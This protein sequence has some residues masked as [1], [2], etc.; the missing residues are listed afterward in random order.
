MK[1]EWNILYSINCSWK[2][3]RAGPVCIF[4]LSHMHLYK[5]SHRQSEVAPLK[6]GNY[7]SV[8]QGEVVVKLVRFH[9]SLQQGIFNFL[10]MRVFLKQVNE[11]LEEN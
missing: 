7:T 10:H 5:Y 8:K 9:V 1:P 6:F 2:G 11:N 3:L 4:C